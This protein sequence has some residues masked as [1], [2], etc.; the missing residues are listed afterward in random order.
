MIISFQGLILQKNVVLDGL[1]LPV[2]VQMDHIRQCT[3]CWRYGHSANRCRS[4][5]T[6]MR[7][8]YSA[9]D[10]NNDC[11]VRCA[12][13]GMQHLSNNKACPIYLRIK[14]INYQKSRDIVRDNDVVIS[15]KNPFE[16]DGEDFPPI[17][18]KV[19]TAKSIPAIN[20]IMEI[21]TPSRL[22]MSSSE[23]DL[24]TDRPTLKRH[25]ASDRY[26]EKRISAECNST[27]IIN[28]LQKV[29]FNMD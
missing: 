15:H 10:K 2:F 3:N 23:T 27:Q 21:S 13:C 17:Q 29:F 4:K 14:D 18:N 7:C 20:Q 28:H 9:H 19:R 1:I 16:L 5:E 22:N 26:I 8:G 24:Q 25:T 11:E 12:N 6:C